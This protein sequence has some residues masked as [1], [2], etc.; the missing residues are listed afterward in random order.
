M[1]IDRV[2]KQKSSPRLLGLLTFNHLLL[3]T[4]LKD[5]N[6]ITFHDR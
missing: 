3:Q 6:A 4:I 2:Y 5:Y 1:K